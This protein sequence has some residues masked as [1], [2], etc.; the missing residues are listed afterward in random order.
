MLPV[1][2]FMYYMQFQIA[3]IVCY[4]YVCIT[5][6]VI[7]YHAQHS[8]DA[9]MLLILQLT[10]MIGPVDI[11]LSLT[12]VIADTNTCITSLRFIEQLLAILLCYSI[13][14]HRSGH[15]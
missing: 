2:Y 5:L 14:K 6:T 9:F 10:G 15:K 12:R 3:V 1:D 7:V 8:A 11:G 4:E 13:K